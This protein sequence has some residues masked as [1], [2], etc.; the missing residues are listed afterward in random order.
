MRSLLGYYDI[1][2]I[3]WDVKFYYL[4]LQCRKQLGLTNTL[5]VLRRNVY[6]VG[7]IWYYDIMKNT[8]WYNDGSSLRHVMSEEAL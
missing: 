4:L 2:S 3:Q 8:Y 5:L 7:N 1:L 6:R